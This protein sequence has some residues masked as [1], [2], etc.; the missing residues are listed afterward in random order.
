MFGANSKKKSKEKRKALE[1]K[2][3]SK[4]LQALRLRLALNALAISTGMVLVL[5]VVWKGGEQLL[6]RY[7]Y[8]NPSFA[9]QEIEILTD[10]IIPLEEIQ[11][12]SSVR[13]GEN[14][15]SLDLPRIKRNL[16]LVPLIEQAYV[17]RQLPRRLVIRVSEREPIAR[18]MV[19]QPRPSD[20]LLE[21]S[22]FYVDRE[23][24]VIPPYARTLNPEAFD[25]AT[26]SLPLLNGVLAQ[27]LR[28]GHKVNR[29]EILN[30]LRWIHDF[31]SSEMAH[32]VVIRAVDLSEAGTLEISTEQG[33]HVTF[34]SRDFE[35]Q[36]ARW[37]KVHDFALRNSRLIAQLDLAVTNYVPASWLEITNAPPPVAL[38]PIESPYR[39]KHV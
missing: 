39:K 34:R 1:V 25:R 35:G 29:A 26:Q 17:E 7:V 14:L 13:Q 32:R 10:G 23:G 24:M 33:N 28:T 22:I 12:W 8:T 38:P 27:E 4:S 9:L 6:Q 36:F 15:L 16:E 21:P 18:I 37:R 20:G 11:R 30:A 31:R 2:S 3:R 5:L 19:F